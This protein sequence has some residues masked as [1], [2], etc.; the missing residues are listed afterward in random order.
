M[1]NICIFWHLLHFKF[2]V[3]AWFLTILGIS[4]HHCNPEK[5]DHDKNQYN[6]ANGFIQMQEPANFQKGEYEC[7]HREKADE[8]SKS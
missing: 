2:K 6:E 8:N 4:L 3:I 5:N 7:Q 1:K